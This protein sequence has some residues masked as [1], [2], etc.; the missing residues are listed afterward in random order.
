M[1]AET[2][3]RHFF[4]DI[5]SGL[6]DVIVSSGLTHFT[7]QSIGWQR[8]L[9]EPQ[10]HCSTE[11]AVAN[12]VGHHHY[13][14]IQSGMQASVRRRAAGA[15][16]VRP[17]QP[18]PLP[19]EQQSK[20]VQLWCFFIAGR[21]VRRP[22]QHLFRSP[23]HQQQSEPPRQTRLVASGETGDRWGTAAPLQQIWSQLQVKVHFKHIFAKNTVLGDWN[24]IFGFEF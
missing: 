9:C 5:P 15:H 18:L 10:S 13:G 1:G 24:F 6:G 19:A 2:Q 17:G 21:T 16:Q 8:W 23:L 7:N 3:F 14:G 4:V 22:V 20:Q 11:D 12:T